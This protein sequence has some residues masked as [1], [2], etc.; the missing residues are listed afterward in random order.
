MLSAIKTVS[1]SL[2]KILLVKF[3]EVKFERAVVASKTSL[4]PAARQLGR[5]QADI[6]RREAFARERG[7][8]RAG[9]EGVRLFRPLV[10]SLRPRPQRSL[11][12]GANRPFCESEM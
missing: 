10:Q 1:A 5:H 9:S 12:D 6:T 2:K 7:I 11:K 8:P 3:G 4:K